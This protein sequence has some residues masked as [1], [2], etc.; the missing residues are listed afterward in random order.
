MNWAWDWLWHCSVSGSKMSS[1]L[2]IQLVFLFHSIPVFSWSWFNILHYLNNGRSH[3]NAGSCLVARVMSTV[4]KLNVWYSASHVICC[5]QCSPLASQSIT[6]HEYSAGK[7][8]A[9]NI[10]DKCNQPHPKWYCRLF[11]HNRRNDYVHIKFWISHT[12]NIVIIVVLVLISY[13][14]FK[15]SILPGTAWIFY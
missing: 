4:K 6:A 2:Q 1:L 9:L 7:Y 5:H 8:I 15:I 12:G 13:R 10:T 14:H 11:K 3:I